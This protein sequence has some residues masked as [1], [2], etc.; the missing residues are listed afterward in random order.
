MAR[1]SN[2]K[3][4]LLYLAKIFSEQTDETHGLT[5]PELIAR[6]NDVHQRRPQDDLHRS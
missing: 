5:M 2:Q 6:L 1:S 3:A 4:K